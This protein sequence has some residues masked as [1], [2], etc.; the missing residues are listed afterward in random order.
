MAYNFDS[1]FY[2]LMTRVDHGDP[3]TDAGAAY[4][5]EAG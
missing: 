4:I 2:P 3:L 1:D 5:Y